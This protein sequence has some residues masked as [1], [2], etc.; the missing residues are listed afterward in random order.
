MLNRSHTSLLRFTSVILSVSRRCQPRAL[1]FRYIYIFPQKPFEQFSL[2]F[3]FNNRSSTSSTICTPC[4]IRLYKAMT[5]I[6]LKLS[7]MPTWW[8]VNCVLFY[9]FMFY[10]SKS[11]ASHHHTI[12]H[13][14]R[15][16]AYPYPT[17]TTQ[18]K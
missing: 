9:A 17:T 2:I 7:V 15:C 12:L 8:S 14:S 6:K 10:P 18:V 16:L 5:C 3:F 13:V 4:S 1:L 11:K